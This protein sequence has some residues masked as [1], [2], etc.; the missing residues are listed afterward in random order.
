MQALGAKKTFALMTI[1]EKLGCSD[2]SAALS[3]LH[4][5]IMKKNEERMG[6]SM[7]YVPISDL[8]N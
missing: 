3:L 7:N 2:R 6:N 5:L 8:F 4:R 1:E